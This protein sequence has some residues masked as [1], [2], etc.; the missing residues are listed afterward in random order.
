MKK[1][2]ICEGYVPQLCEYG[3]D[4]CD[5]DEFE[6]MCEQHKMDRLEEISDMRN[7]LD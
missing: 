5:P 3:V 7:D 1:L 4:G 6:T 2:E